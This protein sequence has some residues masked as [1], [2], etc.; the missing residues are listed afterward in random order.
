MMFANKKEKKAAWDEFVNDNAARECGL[1][2]D[3]GI[4]L[5]PIDLNNGR[6][7]SRL[8]DVDP[9][10]YEPDEDLEREREEEREQERFRRAQNAWVTWGHGQ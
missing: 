7:L 5:G 6:K 1:V 9:K 2:S 10:D 8:F 3:D 4:K